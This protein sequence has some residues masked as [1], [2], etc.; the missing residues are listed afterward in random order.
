LLLYPVAISPL[1]S[2]TK[3]ACQWCLIELR[4]VL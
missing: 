4:I 2:V 1:L 3:H